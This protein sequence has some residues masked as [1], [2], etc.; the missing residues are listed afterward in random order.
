MYREEL[1]RR[2]FWEF[3]LYMDKDFFTRRAFLE[4]VATDVLQPLAVGEIN[5]GGVSMAPRAGK[6]YLTTLFTVWWLGRNPTLCVMRNACTTTLYE[7]FS[8]DALAVVRSP[9]W[10]HVFPGLALSPDQQSVGGWALA[11]SKQGSYFGGGVGKTI[12]GFG[13]NLAITDDLYAG[14]AEALSTTINETTHLWKAGTH[15]SRKERGCPELYV[16][17]RWSQRD[18]IGKAI[19]DKKIERMVTVPALT[20]DR[21][22]FCEDVRTTE[23]YIKTEE[24]VDQMIWM[25]EY[26][27]QPIEAFGLLFPGSQLHFYDPDMLPPGEHHSVFIDPANLGGDYFASIHAVLQD[28]AIYVPHVFCNREGADENNIMHHEYVVERPMDYMEYEGVMQWQNKAKALRTAIEGDLDDVEFRISN[29]T[30]AKATRILVNAGFVR[31]HFYF[32]S[33]WRN[34]PEY[35]TFMNLLTSYL[36][37]QTGQNKAANDDPPDVLAAAA[38]YYQRNFGH[39]W[40]MASKTKKTK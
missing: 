22:S 32:R 17:T 29:P 36:R 14:F 10:Q 35:R 37:D 28:G 25:A 11:G 6:S 8:R 31:R 2:R 9:K 26:M 12:I 27:Q 39:V 13:A 4:E 21:R 16:G 38:V 24:D 40:E 3:C 33:D 34:F 23:E 20:E 5:T 15:D 7:K 30:V 18:V 19:E 1:A